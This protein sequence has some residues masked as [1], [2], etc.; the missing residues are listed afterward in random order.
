MH[1]LLLWP[2]PPPPDLARVLD[3][4]GL[5]RVAVDDEVGARELLFSAVVVW[6]DDD[7]TRA[8][9]FARGLR[10]GDFAPTPLLLCL[11]GTELGELQANS[12]A[13]DDFCVVPAHPSEL[14]ARIRHLL[15]RTGTSLELPAEIVSYE[16]LQLNVET[17]Q[18]SI[19]GSPLDLT[20][21]EYELLKFLASSPGR[22][23]SRE[24]LLSHVWGYD[25]YGGARTVDVHIR[26]LRAK[27]GEQ[28]AAMIQTVRSVG[29]R[30]G[31]SRWQ[32]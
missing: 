31:E 14:E 29:Y 11:R 19:D 27:L 4:I 24:T 9:R 22:V 18:A 12:D 21:M 15:S 28:H 3:L 6:G 8:F 5:E 13:F 17:Y 1:P 2:E 16:A 10:R 26:R 23:F 7:T 25:Y 30:F 20:Y 32:S